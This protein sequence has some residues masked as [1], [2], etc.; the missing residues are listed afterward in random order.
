MIPLPTTP[1]YTVFIELKQLNSGEVFERRHT[2]SSTDTRVM[3]AAIRIL[4]IE[5]VLVEHF[6]CI[7]FLLLVWQLVH[8]VSGLVN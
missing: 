4:C 5:D 8:L 2:N 1:S 7:P 3:S 6:E